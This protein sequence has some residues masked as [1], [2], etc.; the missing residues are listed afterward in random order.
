[1]PL[2]AWDVEYS[3]LCAYADQYGGTGHAEDY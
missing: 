3:L 2:Q 1:M